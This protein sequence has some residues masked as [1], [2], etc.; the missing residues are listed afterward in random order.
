MKKFTFLLIL[1]TFV[2]FAWGQRVN[3]GMFKSK[4]MER[5]EKATQVQSKNTQDY[6]DY[7]K[8]VNAQILLEEH[9]EGTFP[10][11]GWTQQIGPTNRHWEQIVG[12]NFA[13]NGTQIAFHYWEAL[14][15]PSDDWLITPS[16]SIPN[17]GQPSKL[18]FDWI[19]TYYWNVDPNNNANIF[20]KVSA[21]GGTTW[22][23]IWSED[24]S[25]MIV[26]SGVEWPWP[27]Y[28][29]R[30]SFVDLS[31]Y[32]GQNVIFAFQYTGDDGGSFWMDNVFV[33][34]APF[35]DIKYYDYRPEFGWF[36]YGCLSKI[37]YPFP[38]DVF[39][40]AKPQSYGTDSTS[41]VVLDVDINDGTTSVFTGT[42]N[43]S[44]VMV[45]LQIDSLT[46]DT[47]TWFTVNNPMPAT[48]ADLKAYTATFS[49][50]LDQTD[51]FPNDNIKT[52]NFETTDSVYAR[53]NDAPAFPYVSP[54]MW[55]DGGGDGDMFG[56]RFDFTNTNDVEVNS[57][58]MHISPYCPP[59][60]TISGFVAMDDGAGSFSVVLQTAMYDIQQ[61]DSA[62]WLTLPFVKDGFS[63]FLPSGTYI[64]GV[65]I[66]AYNGTEFWISEDAETPQASYATFWY[67][68]NATT[69]GWYYYGNYSQTP[70]IRLNIN[71]DLPV[72]INAEQN[73]ISDIAVYPNP[74]NGELTITNVKNADVTVYNLVGEVV[75]SYNNVFSKV[76]ISELSNGSYIIKIVDDNNTTTKK[77]NLIK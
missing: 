50:G 9:F 26:N 45:E 74:T 35:Y 48:Q 10:P 61:S 16:V 73:N 41:N 7:L 20:V 40:W 77:I 39:F 56:L 36:N 71:S 37:P 75:A 25:T 19:S 28:E 4:Y 24:D 46:V 65:K 17:N 63:E 52:Y 47:N 27:T 70:F 76:D 69:P 58:S 30:T 13:N 14:G 5:S 1:S 11:T 49:L 57:V 55:V 29:W 72:S 32:A 60:A 33:Y 53:D 59:G 12:D 64:A 54:L 68:V 6:V 34:E 22:D 3:S 18:V 23:I 62:T 2:V 44:P 67:L 38:M 51:E 15:T 66:D 42:S 43:V 31:A 21:D 8:D